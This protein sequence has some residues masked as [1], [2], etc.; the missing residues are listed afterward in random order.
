MRVP[1]NSP[2]GKIRKIQKLSSE[3]LREFIDAPEYYIRLHVADNISVDLL[4]LMINDENN[5]V[6]ERVAE[7][8]DP[9][10]LNKLIKDECWH[11]RM[12]V[13]ERIDI[14]FL[15]ELL[16]DEDPAVIAIAERRLNKEATK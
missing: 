3:Q 1:S 9:S 12:A 16:D 5:N 14:S 8:I 7:R 2:A 11:V 4:P 13:A 6:R 10:Q 15:S